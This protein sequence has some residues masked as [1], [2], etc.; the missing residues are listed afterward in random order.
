M[1]VYPLQNNPF[2]STKELDSVLTVCSKLE[3]QVVFIHFERI[4]DQIDIVFVGGLFLLYKQKGLKFLLTGIAGPSGNLVFDPIY[5][6]GVH[7]FKQ[8]IDQI[9]ELYAPEDDWLSFYGKGDVRTKKVEAPTVYAPVLYIDE[10]NL[11]CFF[12]TTGEDLGRY[13]ENYLEKLKKSHA[14]NIEINYFAHSGNIADDLKGKSPIEIF[15]FNLLYSV[16]SPFVTPIEEKKQKKSSKPNKRT[17]DKEQNKLVAEKAQKAISDMK[18]FA[19]QFVGGLK[20]LAKNIVA[21]S[22]FKK[23]IITLRAYM[24]PTGE[25]RNLETFVFDYGT[26]GIIPQMTK[27][28]EEQTEKTTEDLE[29]LKLLSSKEFH[30]S[31]LM[32]RS[33]KLLFRQIHREMAHLGLIHFVSLIR[34]RDGVYSVTTASFDKK[35]REEIGENTRE[36]NLAYGTNFHFTLPLR[37]ERSTV[38]Q[39]DPTSGNGMSQELIIA[40]SEMLKTKDCIQMAHLPSMD[41]KT[42]EDE[43][44]LVQSAA[45]PKDNVVFYAVDFSGIG[46]ISATSLLRILALLSR[47]TDRNL[48]AYNIVTNTFCDMLNVNEEYFTRLKEC[49]DVGYWLRGKSVLIYSHLKEPDEQKEEEIQMSHFYFAD[50]LFGKNKEEFIGVNRAISHVFPNFVSLSFPADQPVE[51]SME[52]NEMAPVRPFFSG[53]VLM[54]FDILLNGFSKGADTEYSIFLSNLDYLL[55]KSINGNV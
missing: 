30:L 20:E 19:E 46:S 35:K 48:I 7:A 55:N 32:E 51:I 37:K 31:D 11:D 1:A 38:S 33:D 29:D 4:V 52:G 36:R 14:N 49:T 27:D 53:L 50:L 39:N 5:G 10:K 45:E 43:V 2:V 24:D 9:K 26:V 23:G 34:S 54:P 6:N 15:V 13:K 3:K 18:D 22:E 47:R 16:K 25:I 8:Y 12:E 28:L 41:V 42:R 17:R 21:H 44:H 40:M